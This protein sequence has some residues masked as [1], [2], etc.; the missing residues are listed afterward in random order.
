MLERATHKDGT[1]PQAQINGYR[2]AG[3][4]GTAKKLS[5]ATY[6]DGRY[7]ASFAGLAPVSNPRFVVAV[8]IDEPSA[9]IFYGGQ[10]SAPIFSSVMA[11]TLRLFEVPFDAPTGPAPGAPASES[12][13][14]I[15]REGN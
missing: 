2:V 5:G 9:G 13:V 7:V 1:A 15:V 3:K 10:V 4:T 11:Q 12:A 6:A 14:A 8:M